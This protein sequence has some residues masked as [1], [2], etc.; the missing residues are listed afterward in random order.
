MVLLGNFYAYPEFQKT[1]GKLQPNG[2]YQVPAPWQA[3]LSN[4]S[5]IGSI[6][7]LLVSQVN[8]TKRSFTDPF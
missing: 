8:E 7:G 5:S 6:M 3:G 4:S 1:F 2:K